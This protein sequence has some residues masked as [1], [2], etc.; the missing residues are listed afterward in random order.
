MK[1]LI[2]RSA[3]RV[4][5]GKSST[6]GG[7]YSEL[8]SWLPEYL[9]DRRRWKPKIAPTLRSRNLARPDQ[10][11]RSN[12]NFVHLDNNAKRCAVWCTL[13]GEDSLVRR[14]RDTVARVAE[15]L[16]SEGWADFSRLAPEGRL[17]RAIRWVLERATRKGDGWLEI[18]RN[19]YVRAYCQVEDM[20]TDTWCRLVIDALTVL[21]EED[22]D[23]DD[24][25]D[26]WVQEDRLVEKTFRM[27][28]GSLR[29]QEK[30]EEGH[31]WDEKTNTEQDQEQNQ[32]RDTSR[33]SQPPYRKIG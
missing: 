2:S 9:Q 17:Y 6:C 16:R 13:V 26:G 21:V 23:E 15:R 18:P 30:R 14:D 22:F 25:E 4:A 31:L 3:W 1:D 10:L 12:R 7:D 20:D 5:S 32:E 28:D 24:G 29:T 19:T 11:A 27:A 8:T 33:R